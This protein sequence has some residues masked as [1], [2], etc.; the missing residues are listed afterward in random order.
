MS[1]EENGGRLIRAWRAARRDAALQRRIDALDE[2]LARRIAKQR[3]NGEP[4]APPAGE[5]L[6]DGDCDN[7]SSPR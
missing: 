3:D 2:A 5:K 1:D 4:A 7:G 6:G